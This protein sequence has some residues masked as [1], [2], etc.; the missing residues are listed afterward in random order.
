MESKHAARWP[1][2]LTLALLAGVTLTFVVVFISA[3]EPANDAVPVTD[4]YAERVEVLLAN[5]DPARGEALLG[6]I[7]CAAC[8]ILAAE[9]GIAPRFDGVA[10]R[11][12]TRRPPLT[13]AEY[14]YESIT[15]PTAYV[16]EGFTGSMPQNFA[17]RLTDQQLGDIMAYLLTLK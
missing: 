15:H 1:V 10:T 16:V 2:Y 8:H 13:A 7:D 9:T 12:A 11:A 4:T 14:I 17:E 3:S 6:P 5:A